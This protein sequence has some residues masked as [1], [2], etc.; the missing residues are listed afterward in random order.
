MFQ[1]PTQEEAQISQSNAMEQFLRLKQTL[2]RDESVLKKYSAF[3][4]EFLNLG[5]LEKVGSRE[6]ASSKTNTGVCLDECLLVGPKVQEDLFDIL[7][8]FRFFKNVLA[9]GTLKKA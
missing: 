8:R 7:L 3:I 1:M 5:H 4:Q 9:S 6:L 2:D